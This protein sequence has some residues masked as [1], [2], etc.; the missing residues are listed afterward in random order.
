MEINS[1]KS[2]FL[3]FVD[4]SVPSHPSCFLIINLSSFQRQKYMTSR[5]FITYSAPGKVSRNNFFQLYPVTFTDGYL[6][7]L[8]VVLWVCP[9][10]LRGDV[11][12]ITTTMN[13]QST[14]FNSSS[15]T[16]ASNP[17]WVSYILTLDMTFWCFYHQLKLNLRHSHLVSEI[18]LCYPQLPH[19][20]CLSRSP[21]WQHPISNQCRLLLILSL[22]LASVFSFCFPIVQPVPVTWSPTETTLID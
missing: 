22:A 8:A 5:L 15:S 20:S 7:S 21:F 19:K 4:S 14:T 18:T 1:T 16:F 13:A 6:W 10:V 12:D 3:M 17:F 11:F 9:E 2:V